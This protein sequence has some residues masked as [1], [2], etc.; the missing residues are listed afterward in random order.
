MNVD[1]DAKETRMV[2][3]SLKL[4]LKQTLEQ[5]ESLDSEDDEHTFLSN[6][7]GMI[8]AIIT[9]YEESYRERFG[10]KAV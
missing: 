7:A 8:D 2:I 4:M 1:L 3:L 9:A 6:D 5:L 10:P